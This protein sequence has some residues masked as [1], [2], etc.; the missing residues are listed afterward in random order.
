MEN[1]WEILD[2]YEWV[3]KSFVWLRIFNNFIN[4]VIW[5]FWT[6]SLLY[7]L[8]I[9]MF[10]K[11]M[12]FL[13]YYVFIYSMYLNVFG[14]VF[15]DDYLYR[16]DRYLRDEQRRIRIAK[17]RK[18]EQRVQTELERP[19]VIVRAKRLAKRIRKYPNLIP[20]VKAKNF[21]LKKI[22]FLLECEERSEALDL[23]IAKLTKEL[24]EIDDELDPFI[25]QIDV[26]A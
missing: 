21:D 12:N 7:T 8:W 5:T 22:L 3:A 13:G 16:L 14:L 18:E 25:Y 6:C 19:Q 10:T 4:M 26:D 24:K 11:Q 1:D 20:F 9:F 23:K 2:N 17:I 15:L